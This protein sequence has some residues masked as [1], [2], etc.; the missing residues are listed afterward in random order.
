VTLKN[1]NIIV[2]KR[3]LFDNFDFFNSFVLKIVCG[4]KK[5]PN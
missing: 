2:T 3:I 5:V 1:L 4:T